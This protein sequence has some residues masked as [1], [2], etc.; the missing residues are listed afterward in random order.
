MH[1]E[2]SREPLP[3]WVEWIA[4]DADGAWWDYSVQPNEGDRGWYENEVGAIV[5][6]GRG[7]PNPRWRDSLRRRKSDQP[8]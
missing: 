2:Q 1:D 4:Q 3:D 7:A 8:R 6:L 5:A